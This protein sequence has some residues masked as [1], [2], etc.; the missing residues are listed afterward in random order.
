MSYSGSPATTFG[1]IDHLEGETIPVLADGVVTSATVADG[2]FTLDSSASDVHAGFSYNTNIETLIWELSGA[3]TNTTRA[4]RKR[5][6]D[7]TLTLYET[8]EL[9]Y[10]PDSDNLLTMPMTDAT[11]FTGDK[12]V[13]FN[14]NPEIDSVVYLRQDDPLPLTLIGITANIEVGD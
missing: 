10:G 4:R 12:V 14:G 11:L 1:N 3:P 8:C 13:E 6:I 2:E 7:L 5:I 9:T